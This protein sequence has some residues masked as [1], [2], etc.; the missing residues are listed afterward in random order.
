MIRKLM[1]V[2]ILIPVL[3]LSSWRLREKI[4]KWFRRA[5][6]GENDRTNML[7]TKPLA[8]MDDLLSCNARRKRSSGIAINS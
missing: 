5:I 8:V 7:T 1:F 6:S 3:G 2:L 4:S